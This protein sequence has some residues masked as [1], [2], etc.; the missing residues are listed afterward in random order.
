MTKQQAVKLAVDALPHVFGI[1]GIA[2]VVVGIWGRWGWEWAAI[3]AG[4]LPAGFYVYGEVRRARLP[5][6]TTEE[7]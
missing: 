2:L 5:G 7:I 3:A 4:V 6:T 1:A